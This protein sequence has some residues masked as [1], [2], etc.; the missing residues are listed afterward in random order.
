MIVQVLIT[1][2]SSLI[3]HHLSSLITV[4]ISIDWFHPAFKAG[5]PIQSIANLVGQYGEGEVNFKIFCSNADLDGTINTGVVF[6]EWCDYNSHTQVWYASKR[7]QSISMLKR[8]MNNTRADVLFVIGIYSWRF[9]MLPLLF[10][11]A[12]LKIISVRGMLHPGALSQKPLKKKIYLA[13]WKLAGIHRRYCFH[14]TDGQERDYIHQ[15]FGKK[16]TVLIAGN[17]PGV[18]PFQQSVQKVP[19]ELR[20]VSIAL[21]SPMKNIALVLD[22]LATCKQQ[23]MYDIYG[24]VKD[25]GYWQD[26]L[27]KIGMLPANIAVRYQGVL[28]PSKIASTLSEYHVFIL[29]SRS[30]NFGHAIYEALSAGRPVITSHHTPFN[31][32]YEQQAGR[33]V[34]VESIPEISRAIA[35]FADMPATDFEKWNIGANAYAKKCINREQLKMQYDRLFGSHCLY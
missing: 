15:V 31:E 11:P 25:E 7:K 1:H 32:L 22:A 8:E 26:C 10:G 9:N 17:Y 16:A 23:V 33:N 19:G 4:F 20:M 30:E 29:P 18:L 12:R 2:Y 6:D 24:P 13:T 3:T 28:E 27:V 5:G 14:A 34:A 21:I 35:F